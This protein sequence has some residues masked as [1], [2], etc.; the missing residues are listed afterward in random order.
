[1]P[2]Q[3][4][5]DEFTYASAEDPWF[6]R[7][8]IH[9]VEWL[10]GQPYLRW[11]YEDYLRYPPKNETLWA[12]GVRRFELDLRYDQAKLDLWPKTGP[13]VVVCNHPYGVLDGL[14]ACAIVAKTRPDFRVLANAVLTRSEEIRSTILPIDFDETKE[15]LE[16]NLKSRAEAKNH[17]A[18][19]GC[20]LIFPSGAVSTTPNWRE[21]RAVDPEWKSFAARMVVQGHAAVVPL[22]FPGQNGLLFQL[23]SHIS[24][25]LRL[26]LLFYELHNKIGGVIPVGVG[27]VVPYEAVAAIKD[28]KAQT[29]FLRDITYALEGTVPLP[30]KPKFRRPRSAPGPDVP[31]P[32]SAKP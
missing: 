7:R 4:A 19:G 5:D 20:L 25:I 1:M 17:V 31:V 23:V 10:T 6:K 24:L 14:V 26:A 3:V 13:L 28:R 22:Y 2:D 27:E 18:N 21:R 29:Q 12:S 16:T 8:I 11:L 30:S 9:L 32:G 15:A